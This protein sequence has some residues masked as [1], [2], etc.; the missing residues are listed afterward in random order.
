MT[1]L[2]FL[3]DLFKTGWGPLAF[4]YMIVA[5]VVFVLLLCWSESVIKDRI[6]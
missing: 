5:F 1:I 3:T 2:D 6:R 4:L